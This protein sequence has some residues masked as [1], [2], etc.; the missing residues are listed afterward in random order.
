MVATVG[1]LGLLESLPP[2]TRARFTKALG[3]VLAIE[4]GSEIAALPPAAIAVLVVQV[5]LLLDAV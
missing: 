1:A 2:P 5:M 4:T 3:A